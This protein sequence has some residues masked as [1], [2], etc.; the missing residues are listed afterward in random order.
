ML[1]DNFGDKIVHSSHTGGTQAVGKLVRSE[2]GD[3][4]LT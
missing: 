2:S 3:N 4:A 1:V